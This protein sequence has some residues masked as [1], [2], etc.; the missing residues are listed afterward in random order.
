MKRWLQI[1][2]RALTGCFR[3][4][5][6]GWPCGFVIAAVSQDWQDRSPED[7]LDVRE[8]TDDYSGG[9]QL[10]KIDIAFADRTGAKTYLLSYQKTYS[11]KEGA[12]GETMAGLNPQRP[13]IVLSIVD[14]DSTFSYL[15]MRN[16]VF[17]QKVRMGMR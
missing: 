17:G 15:L 8:L 11:A 13:D 1:S 4:G 12:D 3:H 16:T 7:L 5:F 14:G 6:A 2:D 10:C 9:D